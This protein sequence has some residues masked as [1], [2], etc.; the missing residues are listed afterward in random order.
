MGVILNNGALVDGPG[1]FSTG[2][3][4]HELR[5][6]ESIFSPNEIF[7]PQFEYFPEREEVGTSLPRV[8]PP[9]PPPT[10]LGDCNPPPPPPPPTCIVGCE[11][12]PPPEHVVPEPDGFGVVFLACVGL[13]ALKRFFS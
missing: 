9:P 7:A 8:P 11:P 10:C 1:E 3:W 2:Q 12:P 13:L 5:K 4:G 6:Y